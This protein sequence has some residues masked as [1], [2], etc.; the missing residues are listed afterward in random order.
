MLTGEDQ[1]ANAREPENNYLKTDES[2]SWKN[3]L[4]LYDRFYF[5]S[6]FTLVLRFLNRFTFTKHV[7]SKNKSAVIFVNILE[8]SNK[9]TVSDTKIR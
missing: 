9:K 8:V 5:I 3:E 7:M 1:T 2:N 6:S 4:S